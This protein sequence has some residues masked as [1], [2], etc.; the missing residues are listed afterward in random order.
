M[1]A[2]TELLKF[3]EDGETVEA[4]VFGPWGWGSA[5]SEGE[6]WKPGYSEPEPPAVPYDKRGVVLSW[7]EARG[8]M[9]SWNFYGGYGAPNAYATYIWT[10]RRVI[11]VTQYDGSTHLSAAPRNPSATMP[12]M[13]GG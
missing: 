9:Q 3:L 4:V 13:P 12:D 11:L 1:S 2:E 8:M 10:N 6:A 5:P 7:E